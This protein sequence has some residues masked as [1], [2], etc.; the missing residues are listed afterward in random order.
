MLKYLYNRH[1][2]N[3][4][5]PHMELRPDFMA[6]FPDHF[7]TGFHLPYCTFSVPCLEQLYDIPPK[8]NLLSTSRFSHMLS[9]SQNPSHLKYGT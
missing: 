1:L 9:S 3:P 5:H 2:L 8:S 6:R 7:P 4:L